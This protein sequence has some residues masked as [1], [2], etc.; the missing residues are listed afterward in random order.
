MLAYLGVAMNLQPRHREERSFVVISVC[1]E[2]KSPIH[3]TISERVFEAAAI[4]TS[5]RSSQ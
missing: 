4:A 2:Y 5:L 3:A 1:L